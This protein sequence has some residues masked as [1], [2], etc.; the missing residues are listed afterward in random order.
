MASRSILTC[1]FL[2]GLVDG[3][4]NPQVKIEREAIPSYVPKFLHKEAV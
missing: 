3:S 4:H 2:N 1:A